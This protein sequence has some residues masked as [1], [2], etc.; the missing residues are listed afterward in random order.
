MN[1]QGAKGLAVGEIDI[2][3]VVVAWNEAPYIAQAVRSCLSQSAGGVETIVIDNCSTDETLQIIEREVAG[4]AGAD[5]RIVRN[6]R[7]LGI[8]PARNQGMAMARGSFI[9]FLDGDD[10]LEP[11]AMELARRTALEQNADVVVFDHSRHH[12]SGRI[13]RG[14]NRQVLG[15]RLCQGLDDR[16]EV[17]RS[18]NSAWNKLY[19]RQ[20]IEAEG[21]AFAATYYEDIDWTFPILMIAPRVACLPEPLVNYRLRQGS[22]LR[23]RNSRH[24]DAFVRWKAVFD[25]MHNNAP[26]IDERWKR[27]IAKQLLNQVEAMLRSPQRGS[28]LQRLRFAQEAYRLFRVADPE[29]SLRLPLVRRLRYAALWRGWWRTAFALTLATTLSKN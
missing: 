29:C 8:G 7:N 13:Q 18:F 25:F 3:I 9:A 5:V 26:R 17:A 1:Y 15:A 28:V 2:T 21:L 24:L 4:N 11:N 22:I 16:F 20:F 14:H 12:P 23:S 19:R 27:V 6:S 10:W